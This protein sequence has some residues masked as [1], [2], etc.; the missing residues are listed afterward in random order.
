MR[1]AE[2]ARDLDRRLEEVLL[3]K[4]GLLDLGRCG[5]LSQNVSGTKKNSR[6]KLKPTIIATILRRFHVSI[7][8]EVHYSFLH[9]IA[10]S[11]GEGRG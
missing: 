10:V 9:W 2:E 8:I 11:K 6:K 4:E 7:G 1:F 5:V 3:N